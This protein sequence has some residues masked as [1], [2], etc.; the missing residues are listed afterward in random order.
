MVCYLIFTGLPGKFKCPR[1]RNASAL[2]IQ[3]RRF[4][5]TKPEILK[6]V[7]IVF[8]LAEDI[9]LELWR[10]KQEDEKIAGEDAHRFMGKYLAQLN[11][12][13]GAVDKL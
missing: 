13:A 2:N 4:P 10:A 1:R 6:R 9:F 7:C 12:L 11:K 3:F 5:Q 8:E